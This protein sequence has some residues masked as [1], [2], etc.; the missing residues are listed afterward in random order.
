M[1]VAKPRKLLID[2]SYSNVAQDCLEGP[3]QFRFRFHIPG[4]LGYNYPSIL[5]IEINY[6]L[7][8]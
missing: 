4:S 5:A 8:V 6:L 3:T 7:E 1:A 2:L